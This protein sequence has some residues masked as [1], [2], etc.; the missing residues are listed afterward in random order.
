MSG[1]DAEDGVVPY[2]GGSQITKRQTGTTSFPYANLEDVVTIAKAMHDAGGIPMS[3]DQIANCLGIPD[4]TARVKLA[5][6]RQF[7]IISTSEGK[8]R[9][10]DLGNRLISGDEIDSQ[11][12]KHEAF[13]SVDIYKKA[14]E[15]F[16]GKALPSKSGIENAFVSWG[17][18]EKQKDKAR[19]SFE[20]S[21]TF[22]GFYNATKD[23]IVA[24]ILISPPSS[25][26][27]KTEE[28]KKVEP[29]H[30]DRGA[31]GAISP[32]DPMQEPL[33]HGL[34]VRMPKAGTEWDYERRV[35]WLRLFAS[36]LDIVYTSPNE[37]DGTRYLK[38]E[39][40]AL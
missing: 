12:A 5:S 25:N 38:V 4:S 8:F 17:I 31:E 15:H 21:A 16:R 22:A 36:V 35:Q 7:G 26:I 37:K 14:F 19:W 24:P 2:E 13:L 6:A 33:I 28:V 18:A 3:S 32:T 11:K 20:K 27:Q 1:A 10:T 23:R 9:L 34:L 30:K 40:E 39:I 29:A